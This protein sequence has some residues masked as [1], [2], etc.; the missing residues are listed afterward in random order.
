HAR[1]EATDPEVTVG[2]VALRVRFVDETDTLTFRAWQREVAAPQLAK[3]AHRILRISRAP[4]LVVAGVDVGGEVPG[5][6]SAI[7]LD[8]HVSEHELG[9]RVRV[10]TTMTAHETRPGED[11]VV[12]E[13]H[14][15]AGGGAHARPA[16]GHLAP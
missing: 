10:A 6:P 15:V 14:H 7:Q 16:G 11:V 13:Q 12:E 9:L 4:A 8:R 3:H 5:A 1:L 2:V